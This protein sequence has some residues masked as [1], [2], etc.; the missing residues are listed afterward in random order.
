MALK[1]LFVI[2][3][4][5]GFINLIAALIILIVGFIVASILSKLTRKVLRDLET[6]KILR[7]QAQV[8]LPIE[9]F[10][11]QAVKY[12]VYLVAVIWALNQ[13][14]LT[15]TVLQIILVTLLVIFIIFIILAFKDFIPNV[16]AGFIIYHKGTIKK[17]EQ[18][19]IKNIEGKVIHIDLTEIRLITK[20]KEIVHIPNSYVT[21][22]E[23][24]K[25]G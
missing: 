7:E 3:S 8:R 5:N 11:S 16:V 19:R 20:N 12:V 10:I 15:T 17:G 9:E 2:S 14:G 22:H 1:D 24:I 18:I 23:L 4:T 6:N 21:K 13:I 25:T